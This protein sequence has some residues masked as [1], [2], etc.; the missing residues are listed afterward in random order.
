MIRRME[1]TVPGDENL[2]KGPA[3]LRLLC[4]EK[5]YAGRP[6]FSVWAQEG[7]AGGRTAYLSALDGAYTLTAAADA[8][9]AELA[10]F[11]TLLGAKTV[12]CS[13]QTGRALGWSARRKGV[14]L[15]LDEE[16]PAEDPG[17]WTGELRLH[18]SPGRIYE[19]L[20]AC[21]GEAIQMPERMAF[22]ADLSHRIR[23]GG[24]RCLLWETGGRDIACAVALESDAGA[25]ISG[26]AVLPAYREKGIGSRLL[27][28]LDRLL[29]KEHRTIWTLARRDEAPFYERQGFVPDGEWGWFA[30]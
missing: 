7:P 11:L 26:V 13:V 20:A 18:P 24:G 10:A 12:F 16:L 1:K 4:A 5:V 6:F 3:G 23:H 21:A 2:L 14:A 28:C 30:P 9:F 17:D 22:H 19:V 8:D 29:L 25:Y 15:R 27:L